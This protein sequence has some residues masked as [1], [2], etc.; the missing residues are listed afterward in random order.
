MTLSTPILSMRR[1]PIGSPWEG[2]ATGGPTVGFSPPEVDVGADVVGDATVVVVPCADWGRRA[3]RRW[4]NPAR[5]CAHAGGAPHSGYAT[6]R[7]ISTPAPSSIRPSTPVI[8]PG[9]T[10]TTL[11]IWAPLESSHP[12]I[13]SV[14]AGSVRVH[15]QYVPLADGRSVVST[16]RRLA[17]RSARATRR[18]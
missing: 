12:W 16:S 17:R 11:P 10:A 2:A 18:H 13:H 14:D 8:V 9:R 7:R 3:S 1:M 6:N 15:G 4:A 5:L